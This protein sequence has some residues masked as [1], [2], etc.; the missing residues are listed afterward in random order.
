MKIIPSTS[1]LLASGRPGIYHAISLF[2][3]KVFTN[4]HDDCHDASRGRAPVEGDR[5][6]NPVHPFPFRM[7]TGRATQGFPRHAT[8]LFLEELTHLTVV[9]FAYGVKSVEK[10]TL[11]FL[12]GQKES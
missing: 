4:R 10:M 3:G 6:S 8:V 5:S 12:E 7:K 9:H 11:I 2:T 1:I